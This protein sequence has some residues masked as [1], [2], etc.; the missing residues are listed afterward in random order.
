MTPRSRRRFLA[1]GGSALAAL[2]DVAAG[3][4]A[5]VVDIHSHSDR[6]VLRY[7][8]DESRVRQGITTEITGNCG[9]SAAP[10]LGEALAPTRTRRIPRA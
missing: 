10:L 6:S 9:S 7:P 4:A 3:Q 2:G 1:E 5:R 8:G